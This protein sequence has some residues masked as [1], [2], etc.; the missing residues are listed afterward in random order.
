[1]SSHTGRIASAPSDDRRGQPRDPELWNLTRSAVQ[2]AGAVADA[3]LEHGGW[4]P[5]VALPTVR[6]FTTSG[7]PSL[8]RSRL[9]RRADAPTDYSEL[10]GMTA[11]TLNPIAF[12]DVPELVTLIEYVRG[13]EDLRSR[14]AIT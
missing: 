14:V 9:L 1:M 8:W 12:A 6:S 4:R 10:F 3:Y 5:R 13:R 7:W 11:G 2:S